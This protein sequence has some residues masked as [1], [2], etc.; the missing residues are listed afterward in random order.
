MKY[1]A[2]ISE[3]TECHKSLVIAGLKHTLM[4]YQHRPT[5]KDYVDAN[6]NE[7]ILGLLIVAM[8][9]MRKATLSQLICGDHRVES[10]FQLCMWVYVSDA[11]FDVTWLV[12]I[13]IEATIKQERKILN[14]ELL[15]GKLLEIISGK[16]LFYCPG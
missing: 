12:R 10:H 15:Q 8:G 9:G 4:L 13:I 14:M 3:S 1:T 6:N 7:K 2:L 16:K 11:D 5:Y